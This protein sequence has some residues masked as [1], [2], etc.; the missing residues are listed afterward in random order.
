MKAQ[1]LFYIF[2]LALVVFG[3]K[4]L[5]EMARK[6]GHWAAELRNAAGELR[7]GIEAEVGDIG[8]MRNE[9]LGPITEARRALAKPIDE[10]KRDIQNPMVEMQAAGDE[11]S[12]GIAAIKPT[13]PLRWIGPTPVGGPSAEDAAADLDE[14]NRTGAGVGDEEPEPDR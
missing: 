9:V 14:I 6:A 7:S 5:P 3:P 2:I 8:A 12:E 1:E 4:R 10:I 11:I 13:K